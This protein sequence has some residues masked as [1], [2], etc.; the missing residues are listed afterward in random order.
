MV[1]FPTGS[2]P[3]KPR[4]QKAGLGWEA[5]R[6][7]GGGPGLQGLEGAEGDRLPAFPEAKEGEGKRSCPWPTITGSPGLQGSAGPNGF[8]PRPR[9][10]GSRL[11]GAPVPVSPSSGVD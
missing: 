4:P 8:Q 10:R 6:G 2:S 9:L 1:L 3:G 5:G 11:T 7:K